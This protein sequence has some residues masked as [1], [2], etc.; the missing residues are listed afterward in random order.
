VV[1]EVWLEL[2]KERLQCPGKKIKALRYGP[3]EVLEKVGDNA[4]K[5]RLPL[6]MCI[7][8]VVNVENIKIYEPSILDREIERSKSYL[9]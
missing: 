4:Y 2:S 3:F 6:Y 9:P 5:L 1:H 7:Y 8:S